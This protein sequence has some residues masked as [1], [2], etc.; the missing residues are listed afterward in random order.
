MYDADLCIIAIGSILRDTG[1][2]PYLIEEGI[3][4]QKYKCIFV[5]Y[6]QSGHF[7]LPGSKS[8]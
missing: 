3:Y 2:I 1:Y 6:L 5:N 7:V 4:L 8:R